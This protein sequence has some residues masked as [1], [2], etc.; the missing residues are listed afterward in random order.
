MRQVVFVAV[1]LSWVLGGCGVF[2]PGGTARLQSQKTGAVLATGDLRTRVYTSQDPDTADVYMTDLPESVWNGGADVSDMSGV[3]VHV[4][5]FMRPK[6]GSTPIE[7]TASTAV[8][9]CVVL[10]K[11]EIG[12][13]GGGGFFVN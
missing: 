3:I 11:G 6:A 1:V 12:V 13:Y 9:R 8:I 10:A 4:H 5:M 2:S 7:E